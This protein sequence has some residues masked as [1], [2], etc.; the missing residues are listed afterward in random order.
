MS[1]PSGPARTRLRVAAWCLVLAPI[2]EI[3]SILLTPSLSRHADTQFAATRRIVAR[4]SRRS[5]WT[6]SRSRCSWVPRW[7]WLP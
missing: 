7:C 1:Y 3:A 5:A 4:R 2:V 6:L